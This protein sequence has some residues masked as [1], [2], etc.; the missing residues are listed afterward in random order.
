[1][2]RQGKC[3]WKVV[4]S[5]RKCLTLS[6]VRRARVWRLFCWSWRDSCIPPGKQKSTSRFTLNCRGPSSDMSRFQMGDQAY[7]Q[8][9]DLWR[10]YRIH[11][12]SLHDDHI[13]FSRHYVHAHSQAPYLSRKLGSCIHHVFQVETSTLHQTV[14]ENSP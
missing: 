9:Q 11:S 12:Y 8:P 6:T 7:R 13:P 10:E 5:S 14:D 4:K 3:P 1:M 2:W